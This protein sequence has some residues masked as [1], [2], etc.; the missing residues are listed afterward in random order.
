[1]PADKY[2]IFYDDCTYIIYAASTKGCFVNQHTIV[3]DFKLVHI[4]HGKF[5]DFNS[6]HVPCAHGQLST[7]L[8][9]VLEPRGEAQLS[10]V[11]WFYT[12]LVRR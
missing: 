6:D 3:I 11:A 12:L 4:S 1:M 9:Y 10:A 2:G 8:F 5:V 7:I